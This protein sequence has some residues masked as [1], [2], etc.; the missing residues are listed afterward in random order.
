MATDQTGQGVNKRLGTYLACGDG[1]KTEYLSMHDHLGEDRACSSP[2]NFT[3][4][5][6]VFTNL[7]SEE[8]HYF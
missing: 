8:N 2:D 6:I 4:N 1:D 3:R 7:G 5:R